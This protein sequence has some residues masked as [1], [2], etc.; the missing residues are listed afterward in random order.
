MTVG[1]GGS[2]HVEGG[3]ADVHRA[4]GREAELQGVREGIMKVGAEFSLTAPTLL[5]ASRMM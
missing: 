4:V 5:S 3:E 2:G 1:E